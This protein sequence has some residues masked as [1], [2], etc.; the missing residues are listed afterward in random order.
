MKTIFTLLFLPCVLFA[1]K[2]MR[3]IVLDQVTRKPL[4]FVDVY[5]ANE[6]T[7]SNAEGKFEIGISG[8][9]INFGLIGYE[10][11]SRALDDFGPTVDT[12]Y[13]KSKFLELN[14]V[15]VTNEV[16]S[17]GDFIRIGKNYPFEPFTEAFFLRTSLKKND[18][19]LKLQDLSGLIRRKQLLATGK[20]P[21]PKNNVEVEITNMRKTAKKENEIYF[22]MWGFRQLDNIISSIA[23][24]PKFYDFEKS[25]S[26][27]GTLDKLE[28]K[29]N[30]SHNNPSSRGYYIIDPNDIA[31]Q[32]FYLV[33]DRS[34]TV[35]FEENWG[36]KYRTV[37]FEKNIHFKKN[38]ENG[39]YYMD[40]AKINATVE[41]YDKDR[42]YVPIMYDASYVWLGANQIKAK[43]R[44][45]VSSNKDVLK[46]DYPYN[47]TFWSNQKT[48]MLTGEMKSFIKNLKKE[49]GENQ[50]ISNIE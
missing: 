26:E 29:A 3:G 43:V 47:K 46:L 39:L 18:S 4:E 50:Y 33:E 37:F 16:I 23:M 44:E 10:R 15:V 38:R 49:Q 27:D 9:T 5:S 36:V 12:I 22:E 25:I 7:S 2:N 40:K 20:R 24:S 13:M 48:F 19:L 28:F 8:D 42:P 17:L 45:N 41:L 34:N 11:L 35:P 6:Y 14:E 32:E 30:S 1:Q 31:I 21:R